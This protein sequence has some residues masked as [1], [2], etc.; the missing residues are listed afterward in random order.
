MICQHWKLGLLEIL[1]QE[2]LAAVELNPGERKPA[3][4]I[5]RLLPIITP[6]QYARLGSQLQSDYD[7]WL[8][9]TVTCLTFLTGRPGSPSPNLP[10]YP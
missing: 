9:S 6:Q 5:W 3:L 1:R 7:I 8:A 10:W 2:G 4:Q